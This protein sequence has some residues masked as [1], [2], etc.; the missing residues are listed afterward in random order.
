MGWVSGWDVQSN[1]ALTSEIAKRGVGCER[2]LCPVEGGHS[3]DIIY[4]WNN[5]HFLN[6]RG[7]MSTDILDFWHIVHNSLIYI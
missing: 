4:S 6:A 3:I 7:P 5:T 2:F 1:I